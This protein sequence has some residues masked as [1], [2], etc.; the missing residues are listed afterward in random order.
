MNQIQL[1]GRTTNKIELRYTP[2]GAAVARF[3]LAVDRRGKKKETDFINCIA[4]QKAAEL[5]SEHVRKGDKLGVTG[6]VQTGSY[7]D[8]QGVKRS[9]FDVVVE[10][11]DFLANKVKESKNDYVKPK[12]DYV[13]SKN[14]HFDEPV[15]TEEFD[16]DFGKLFSEEDLPL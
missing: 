6:R 13:K 12:N 4:W 10:N 7:E 15:S 11:F 9:T 8:R 2:N 16:E 5:I 1:I 3:T 14:D